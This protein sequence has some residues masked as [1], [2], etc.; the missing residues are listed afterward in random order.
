MTNF[1]HALDQRAAIVEESA[2]ELAKIRLRNEAIAS[3]GAPQSRP[4]NP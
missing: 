4:P 3:K 1:L 2:I